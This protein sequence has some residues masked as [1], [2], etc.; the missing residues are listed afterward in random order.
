MD[1]QEAMKIVT[2][3]LRNDLDYRRSWEANIAMAFKDTWS[4]TLGV[5]S[6]CVSGEMIH[7]I[8]NRAARHFLAILCTEGETDLPG[9]LA[10]ATSIEEAQ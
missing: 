2:S 7:D 1:I 3:E 8:S 10:L 9:M 6:D 5:N 4:W